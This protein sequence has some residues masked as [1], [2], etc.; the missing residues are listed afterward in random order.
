MS[1]G[2]KGWRLPETLKPVKHRHGFLGVMVSD[3]G[4]VNLDLRLERDA[5]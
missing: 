3:R 4:D 1:V 5:H 2:I